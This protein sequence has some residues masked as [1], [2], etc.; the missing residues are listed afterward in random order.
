MDGG[1]AREQ[2]DDLLL[3]QRMERYKQRHGTC[4]G[5]KKSSHATPFRAVN[6]AGDLLNR[7][8]YYTSGGSNQV[9]TGRIKLQQMVLLDFRR[10]LKYFCQTR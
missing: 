4:N 9:N 5:V 3:R 8:D 2:D 10:N 7:V 6:N 1:S